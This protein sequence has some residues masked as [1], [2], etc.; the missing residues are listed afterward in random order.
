MNTLANTQHKSSLFDAVRVEFATE[1][2][3]ALA[4]LSAAAT[5]YVEQVVPPGLDYL[6]A[7]LRTYLN[8]GQAIGFRYEGI[9]TPQIQLADD[10]GVFPTVTEI[11]LLRPVVCPRSPAVLPLYMR[12]PEGVAVDAAISAMEELLDRVSRRVAELT[13]Q[14]I[15]KVP[16][17]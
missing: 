7:T 10:Y 8:H 9:A 12:V 4:G 13:Q 5:Q 6:S 14:P 17:E 2:G 15:E 3:L 16:N 11:P 1:Y